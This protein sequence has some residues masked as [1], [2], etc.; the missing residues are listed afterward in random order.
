MTQAATFAIPNKTVATAAI[1]SALTGL[2]AFLDGA[3]ALVATYDCEFE[4]VTS[5]IALEP[6]VTLASTDGARRWV[7]KATATR[8]WATVYA[9][10]VFVDPA[11]GNNENDGLTAVT[12]VQTLSEVSRR[13]PTLIQAI[14]I[15]FV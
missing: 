9:P 15:N 10:N 3:T 1:L 7:R 5:A 13:V 4:L 2:T 6:D 14:T 11:A 12:A 8:K